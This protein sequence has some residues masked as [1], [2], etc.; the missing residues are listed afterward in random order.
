MIVAKNKDCITDYAVCLACDHLYELC[1]CIIS[2]RGTLK[3]RLCEFVSF[4][5]HPHHSRQL[6]CNTALMKQIRVG[7]MLKLVARKSFFTIVLY[8]AYKIY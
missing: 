3:S 1:D 5:N 2:E 8:L 6:K 7:G 4:L